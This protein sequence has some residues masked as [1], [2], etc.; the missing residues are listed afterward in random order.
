MNSREIRETFLEYFK[1]KGHTIVPSSPLI[2]THDP[3]LLFVNA[4]MVQFKTFFLGEEKSPY[5]RAVSCQKCLRA[6]GKHSD[7]ENVGHTARHHTFFEML[8]NFSFGNYFKK[9]AILFSWELLTE[10]VRLPKERLYVSIYEKD[11]EA[12]RLWSELIGL[13]EER[14]VRLGAHHNFWQM[15]DTGPCGPCSEII[16]DQG[17]HIGC[18]KPDCSV[19]CECDRFLELWNLVFM[20]FSRDA[21]GTLTPLPEPS[22]DTGMGLERISATLQGKTNNFDSDL[23]EPIIS[24]IESYSRTVYGKDKTTDTSIRVI[25]DHIRAI[26]FLLSERLMP[27]NEGRGYVLRRIIRRASRYAK[28]LGIEGPILYKLLDSVADSLSDV[29][30]EIREEKELSKKI[31]R[32]EEE[33]FSRTLEY[34]MRLIDEIIE[35]LR[36]SGK[37]VIPGEEIFRLY[38]TYGFPVDLARDIAQDN[39]FEIDEAGFLRE[40]E[41][42]RMRARASWVGEEE[43]VAP[44]YRELLNKF[45]T[46]FIG[47]K[48]MESESTV[49]AIIKDGVNIN[50]I[51]EGMEAEIILDKSPF[52]AESGGQVGDKG[53]LRTD[54]TKATVIETKKPI[55][56]LHV[57]TIKVRKGIL[58]VGTKVKC[59]IDR[60]LRIPA[61]RNHTAT[62]LLHAS[63]RT[64]LG[65]HV[66]QSGSL[67]TPEGLRF[68]FTHF[69]PLDQKEIELIE[70]LVNEKILEN[71][72]VET[73]VMDIRDAIDSGAMAL[74]GEKYGDKVRVVK[75]SDFSS[76]LC[77]GTHVSTTGDI[78]PFK[79]LSEGSI[80][81]GVRRIEAITGKATLDYFRNKEYELR[82]IAEML[83]TSERPAHRLEKLLNEMRRLEKE[84]EKLK[85]KAAAE[86][87]SS[88]IKRAQTV[89]GIKVIA[90]R[91]DGLRQKDLRV[92]ADNIRDKIGS[93]ILVLASAKDGQASMVAMVTKDLTERF[94]AG[95]ILK[96]VAAIAGGSGGGR[97][98]MAQG[99][100]KEIERLDIALESVYDIIKKRR[101]L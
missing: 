83:K 2:P 62:H 41:S 97:P 5:N 21:S 91:V 86:T 36:N 90:E 49:L 9:E 19:G 28:L 63:L 100:T 87:S 11:D 31:L 80:A 47:Y 71:I 32:L 24:S 70:D 65:D 44:I 23:F 57:H 16:I 69:S 52:Y 51:K 27:S 92:L 88:I 61:M 58:T 1:S 22:I 39:E 60:S 20:Q 94:N 29:Y 68:D 12:A 74:F 72:R 42:Q 76:E 66:K 45:R 93:G 50:D 35:S 15:G 38:D 30:P 6:G 4:G 8:G 46:E 25:A 59:L 7:L 18:G 54:G 26:A 101:C 14:I 98:E 85:G 95:E 37:T 48:E 77:G 10:W 34:G 64:I 75:I 56:G 3:T 79:I 73:S 99:G 82:N 84:V 81:S 78:G 17:S 89:E 67:V 53:E 55:E 96:E 13:S 40:M 33:R 43:A